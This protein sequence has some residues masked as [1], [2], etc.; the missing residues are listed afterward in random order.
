MEPGLRIEKSGEK[1]EICEFSFNFRFAIGSE[2]IDILLPRHN[3]I[4]KGTN[5]EENI[6]LR[7]KIVKGVEQ[8][9]YFWATYSVCI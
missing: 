2:L 4:E 9:V 7:E 1:L 8:N 6:N 5:K 3:Q